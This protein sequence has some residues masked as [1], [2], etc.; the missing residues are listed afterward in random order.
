MKKRQLKAIVVPALETTKEGKLRGGFSIIGNAG[1]SICGG[2]NDNCDH[3]S[4]CSDNEHCYN[5]S[6]S[7]LCAGNR[8]ST[9]CS[10]N[11]STTTSTSSATSMSNRMTD[12]FSLF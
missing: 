6:D 12:I 1:I 3:N 9:S 7:Q 8:A 5:N 11:H 4:V 2:P 10:S